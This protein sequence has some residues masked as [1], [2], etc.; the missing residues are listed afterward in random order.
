MVVSRRKFLVA[1]QTLLA[2]AALP[3]NFFGAATSNVGSSK[4]ANLAALNKESFLPLVNSS[5]RVHSGSLTRAWFTLLSV[6]DMNPGAPGRATSAAV[7]PRKPKSPVPPLDTF[8]LHFYGTG[9]SLP[10]GTYEFE[11]PSFGRFSMFVVPSGKTTY[12]AIISH[13]LNAGPILAPRPVHSKVQ[14]GIPARLESR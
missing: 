13:L 14:G 2:S 1:G 3:M 6:Q 5:F 8:A 9:E 11:H 7:L 4:T 12:A 10:Q